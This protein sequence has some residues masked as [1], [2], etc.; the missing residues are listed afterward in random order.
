[1]T[2]E[3]NFKSRDPERKKWHGGEMAKWRSGGMAGH[4][5]SAEDQDRSEYSTSC[6]RGPAAEEEG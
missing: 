4:R 1:M 3:E 2:S 5:I 6:R